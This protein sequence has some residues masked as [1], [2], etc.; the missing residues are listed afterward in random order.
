LEIERRML[1]ERINGLAQEIDRS[2]TRTDRFFAFAGD[3][4]FTAG[5]MAKNA[6]PAIDE[7]KEILKIVL[8]SRAKEEKVQLPKPED[9]LR[10]PS[11][12]Q[13]ATN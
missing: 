4:A 8:R 2:G 3:L 5:E 7:F 10:L 1:F 13:S 12:E 11:P 9:V 6:K